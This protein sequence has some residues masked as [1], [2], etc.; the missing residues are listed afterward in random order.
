MKK[1]S[2]FPVPLMSSDFNTGFLQGIFKT[3]KN[4][5]MILNVEK[6]FSNA[7]LSSIKENT[8]H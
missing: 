2:P 4:F 5:T 6:V 8:I 3:G 1:S 7:E